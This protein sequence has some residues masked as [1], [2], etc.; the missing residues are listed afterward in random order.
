MKHSVI[1]MD[2]AKKV[3]Q[4]HT[5]DPETGKIERFKLRRDEVL[6][7]FV[8]RQ[9]CLVAIEAC[10]SAH[11][12]ARQLQQLGHD[13]RL[14]APRSVRPFVLRNKTD[15]ADAQAIW[16]A[17]QQPSA[18]LVAIKQPD[19][20]AILSLHRIRAQLLKFRT[21]QSNGLRGLLY[22]FGI[23]LPEGYA[24]L[25]KAIPEAFADA[26]GK[27][28]PLLLESLREQ[29]AR[30]IRLD[31][32][33]RGIEL[34]LKQYLRERSDCQK[35]AEIPGIGLLTA[36][37]AVASLGDATTFRSGRQFAAWLGLVPR[38]TG[39]GGRVR[40]LGLSK[41]GDTYLRTLLMHGA[42]SIINRGQK[43]RWI[44]LLLARRPYNVVVAALANKLARTLWAV[45]AKGSP[46][47]PELFTERPAGH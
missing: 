32:E 39:T 22:E 13:V 17:V 21:M 29:W 31:E 25:S 46:Y 37:A 28:P 33:I 35:I 30:I 18:C 20:Q 41:R 1:G 43:S 5:V 8:A 38:Q 19:Q 15:A 27:V 10:G 47:Q 7:F 34:R 11:W 23:V 12:W 6:P 42:R 2:I 40:Q 3:F 4:L 16:T 44:E 26:D 9:P 36:T 24:Q 14:L 45:L